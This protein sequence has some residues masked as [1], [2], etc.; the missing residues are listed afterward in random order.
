MEKTIITEAAEQPV[1]RRNTAIAQAFLNQYSKEAAPRDLKKALVGV[2]LFC[3]GTLV[4]AAAT[5][6]PDAGPRTLMSYLLPGFFLV[7]TAVML[8]ELAD[9]WR[10]HRDPN[11]FILRQM[12]KNAPRHVEVRYALGYAYQEGSLGVQDS[13]EA[14]AWYQK[15]SGYAFADNDLGVCCALGEGV[16]KDL[17]KAHRLFKEAARSG[18][19]FAAENLKLAKELEEF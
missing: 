15:A 2:V 1:F 6:G 12:K 11:G 19:M 16:D 3:F 14:A 10:Y 18:V 5:L 7:M 13:R 9:H 8:W 17:H 4:T